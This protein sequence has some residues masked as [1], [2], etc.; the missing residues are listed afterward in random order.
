M[1]GKS[2][3]ACGVSSAVIIGSGLAALSTRYVGPLSSQISYVLNGYVY[4]Y[5]SGYGTFPYVVWW[6]MS[7]FLFITG[8]LLPDIDS[9]TSILG[10]Y[11]HIPLEHRTW[12]HTAWIAIFIGIGAV[13]Y[14]FLFWLVSGYVCHVFWD[15]ISYGGVCWFYP[16]S[17]YRNYGDGAKVKVNHKIK[18]YRTGKTSEAVVVTITVMTALGVVFACAITG[19]Y[20]DFWRM[21]IKG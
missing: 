16:I 2:H 4:P 7:L 8:L 12:T 5:L 19:V 15:A 3:L 20:L 13:F 21:L 14:P 17:K 18:I 11:V 6:G 10:R 1:L 9:K